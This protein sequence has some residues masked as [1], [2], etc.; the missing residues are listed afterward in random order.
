MAIKYVPYTPAVLQGQA[1]LSNFTRTQKILTYRGDRDV[2]PHITRGMPLY[3]LTKKEQVGEPSDNLVIRGECISACAYLREHNIS[4]DLV[5]IDPPFASGA[6]YAK[7]VYLR[8]NP[9]NEVIGQNDVKLDNT[10]LQTFES[11]MYGDI[12]DKERYLNW[13]YENLMAIKSVMS[14]TASIYV[15]LDWHI[16]HYVKILLDE[17]FGENAFRNEIIWAYRIQGISKDT[18]PKKHDTIFYY[19]LNPENTVF[20]PEKEIIT[21]EKPFIDTTCIPP[22]IELLTT[23]QKGSIKTSLDNNKPLKDS[24]KQY[25]FNTYQTEVY[26]RDVWDCD[27]T[28]PLISGS[29]EYVDYK[30]QKPEGLLSR[31]IESSS[32]KGMVV[33]DFFGGSGVTAAVAAKLGRKFIHVDVNSN[34]I[35]TTRDRLIK[36]NASFTH[37]EVQDGV[38]LFRNPVQTMEV[39]PHL[40]PGLTKDRSLSP[41]WAGYINDSQLGKVPVYLPNLSEG[42]QARI[43]SIATIHRLLFEE[44]SQFPPES[45]KKVIVYYIDMEDPDAILN[46]IK[47]Q[48]DTLIKIEFRDLKAVLDNFIA[49]D[50]AEWHLIAP[51]KGT[52]SPWI[53]KIT[54]FFSDRVNRKINEYNQKAISNPKKTYPQITLSDDG[55][56]TIEWL[57][58]DCTN[59]DIN[60]PWQSDAEIKIESDSYIS[61]NGKKTKD[62][63]DAT[64]SSEIRPLRLKIRNI[65]GDESVYSLVEE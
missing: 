1:M 55:L 65:C 23:K 64:I 42:A 26:V 25:L 63:W 39:L 54:S 22:H 35:T 43:L 28:K 33:A 20:N 34:S 17:I 40:I 59:A 52:L 21:Y 61:V 50:E 12:W 53:L 27:R 46:Y 5:Y 29:S 19:S 16:G 24:L 44:I 30:T 15:H 51:A 9:K 57:S 10:D 32:N 18:W 7:K 37:L 38:S 4:V 8:R 3:E 60:A 47:Q 49:C 45:V 14:P 48:N 62:F 6:D 56:E 58:L 13:M 31:I 36:E 41:A 11:K 2:E